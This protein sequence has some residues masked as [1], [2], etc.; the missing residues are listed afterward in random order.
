MERSHFI[1]E[2]KN[3][4]AFQPLKRATIAM[5]KGNYKLIYYTGY[6]PEDTFELYD[7]NADIEELNDLY[8]AQPTIARQMKEEF[9]DS[10][11]DANKPYMK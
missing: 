10:L 2:A 5:Q 6:E 8:P 3:S 4:P 11:L 7:L 9:L 1:V